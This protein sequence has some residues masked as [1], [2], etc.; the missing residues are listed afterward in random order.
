MASATTPFVIEG[1]VFNSAGL[2]IPS[3]VVTFT[4]STGSSSTATNGIGE[5]VFD[6]A[7]IGFSDGDTISFAGRDE[8]RNETFSGTF[9]AEGG[10]KTLDINLSIRSD[11]VA[12]GGNREMMIVNVGGREVSLDNPLPVAMIGTVD[13]I[14]LANNPDW[15]RTLDTKGRSV[16]ETIDVRGKKYVRNL[17]YSGNAFNWTTRSKWRLTE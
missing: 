10:T 8:N 17:T 15:T 3:A 13:L 4:T 1:T 12:P 9:V 11:P 14:D 16:T 2:A 6:L 5:Y 7:N